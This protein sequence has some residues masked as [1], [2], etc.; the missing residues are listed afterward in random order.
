MKLGLAG[1]WLAMVSAAA[2]AGMVNSLAFVS[3][4]TVDDVGLFLLI[5]M[6]GAAGGWIVR[7]KKK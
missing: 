6:L 3:V 1:A 4:P 7:R 5:G 2:S